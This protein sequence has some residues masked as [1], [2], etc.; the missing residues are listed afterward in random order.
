LEQVLIDYL[1]SPEPTTCLVLEAPSVDGRRKWVK[2]VSKVGEVRNCVAPKRPQD[3]RA[4]IDARISASG[5]RPGRGAAAALLERTGADLDRLASEVEKACLY[6]GERETVEVD[7]VTEVTGQLRDLAIYELNDVIGARRLPEALVLMSR[8]LSQGEAPLALL[9]G[10]ANHYRRLIRASECQ[11]LS[12]DQVQR[13]LSIHPF[14]AKKL[15][16]QVRRFDARRLR[17]C[18]DAVRRTD[19]ALKGGVSLS[20]NLAIEQLVLAVCA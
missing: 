20:P 15:V 19:A 11:P 10:L 12:A 7:D 8:L 13:T 4:W 18:L 5:K 14:A 6:V 3:Q 16:E 9:G 1:E 17:R 2:L